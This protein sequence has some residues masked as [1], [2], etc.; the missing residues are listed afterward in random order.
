M[1]YY[2]KYRPRLTQPS[3]LLPTAAL[4]ASRCAGKIEDYEGVDKMHTA[5]PPLVSSGQLACMSV[6]TTWVTHRG[7]WRDTTCLLQVAINT[8]AGTGSELTRFTIITHTGRHT[9][10]AIVDWSG[11]LTQNQSQ[12]QQS[13]HNKGAQ[14]SYGVA[15]PSAATDSMRLLQAVHSQPCRQRPQPDGWHAER[16]IEQNGRPAC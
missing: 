4:S 8:T 9:K 10:M 14:C 13:K 15:L 12:L 1:I 6:F 5:M 11:P 3:T 16:C 2:L 7:H